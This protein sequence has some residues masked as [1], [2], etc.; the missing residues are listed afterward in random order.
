MISIE[1]QAIFANAIKAARN[2]RPVVEVV[3]LGTYTVWGNG[4]DYTVR[5]GKVAG[6][7]FASCTCEA[8]LGPKHLTPEQRENWKPKA[9]RH[10]PSAYQVHAI[11]DGIRKQV[12][13]FEASLVPSI[14]D[15]SPDKEAA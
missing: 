4:G 1:N 11:Q 8:H 5:F 14:S 12:R 9:C 3:K 7:W 2:T 15:W 10:I 6:H 13:A